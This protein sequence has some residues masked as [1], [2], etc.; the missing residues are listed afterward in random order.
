MLD[1]KINDLEGL[2]CKTKRKFQ[3]IKTLSKRK[4]IKILGMMQRTVQKFE[5]QCYY[6]CSLIP[7]RLRAENIC[8]IEEM[9]TRN[10]LT[11]NFAPI[12]VDGNGSN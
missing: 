10:E 12:Q 2:E 1:N 9:S 11:K 4:K 7:T 5:N 8:Q 6:Y 3:R